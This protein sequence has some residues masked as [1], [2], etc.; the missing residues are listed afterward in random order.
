MAERTRAVS[1]AQRAMGP[2]L[3]RDQQRAMA[4]A[5]L[6]RPK[7]GRRPVVP[8]AR[9]GEMIEPRVSVPMPKGMQP[10]ATAA[11]LP[12]LEPEEPFFGSHGL[13][14][15]PLCQRSPMARAPRVVLATRIA[16]ALSSFLMTAASRVGVRLA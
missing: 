7:G 8:Q 11:A 5:R 4:P 6:T 1:S 15:R 14:V 12:A 3:S 16:P 13:L 2:A 10:A 9:E